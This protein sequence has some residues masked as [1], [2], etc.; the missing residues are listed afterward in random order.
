[1][2]SPTK[3]KAMA[4]VESC[5]Q[6]RAR[7]ERD[8]GGGPVERRRALAEIGALAIEHAVAGERRIEAEHSRQDEEQDRPPEADDD[9]GRRNHR[10][11]PEVDLAPS[12]VSR[13]ALERHERD[14]RDHERHCARQNVDPQREPDRRFHDA[15][16]QRLFARRAGAR[17]SRSS[18]LSVSSLHRRSALTRLCPNRSVI[19]QYG[20]SGCARCSRRS[21][22]S[23]SA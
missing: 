16:P 5:H 6:R 21:S 9:G 13:A 3:P 2:A 22:R 8:P 20:S 23:L 10:H 1:M 19:S 11:G 12:P 15:L 17:R 14:R 4:T 18:V 7:R